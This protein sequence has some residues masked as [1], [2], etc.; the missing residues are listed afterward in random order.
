MKWR[1]R[2]G[3]VSKKNPV[4]PSASGLSLLRIFYKNMLRDCDKK[5]SFCVIFVKNAN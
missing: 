4:R 1:R 3:T 5:G 2:N